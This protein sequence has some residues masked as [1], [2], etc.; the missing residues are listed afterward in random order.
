MPTYAVN[1]NNKINTK[2]NKTVTDPLQEKSFFILAAASVATAA[3]FTAPTDRG[4]ILGLQ[5]F[6]DD[7]TPGDLLT[8]QITIAG[9]GVNYYEG[10]TLAK[11]A[12]IYQNANN[13]FFFHATAGSTIQV[14]VLNNSGVAINVAV[15]FLFRPI[16]EGY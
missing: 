8:S 4:D 1:N 3:Q 10:V 9:N 15:N 5:V 7:I 13:E 16:Q 6:L 12:T 14:S 11:F 2:T